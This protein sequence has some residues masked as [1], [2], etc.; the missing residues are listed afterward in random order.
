MTLY[1]IG[2]IKPDVEREIRLSITCDYYDQNWANRVKTA[3]ITGCYQHVAFV[4]AQSLEDVFAIGNGMETE[5]KSFILREKDVPMHSVSVGDLIGNV[6]NGD[7][8]VVAPMG[9][10]L[11]TLGVS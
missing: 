5:N 9:F 2:Q 11:I 10:V 7:V 4:N 8:Y 6:D 3:D 1:S